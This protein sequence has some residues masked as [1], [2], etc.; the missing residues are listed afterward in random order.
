MLSINVK[1]S[2]IRFPFFLYR[3]P[4]VRNTKPK[5]SDTRV[6]MKPIRRIGFAMMVVM[7]L[8][9]LVKHQVSKVV[10]CDKKSAIY[11]SF[12][13]LCPAVLNTKPNAKLTS[14]IMKPINRI[15]LAMIVLIM[16]AI[17]DSSHVNNC[18]AKARKLSKA[19]GSVILPSYL[20]AYFLYS[21]TIQLSIR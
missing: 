4:A 9:I 11:I 16:L 19:V 20:P 18:V 2:C 15:G 12:L 6:I 21:S 10:A 8:P 7:M 1:I 5:A 3:C 17:D 13:Y 14:R